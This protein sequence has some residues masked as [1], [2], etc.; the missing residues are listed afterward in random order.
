MYKLNV[1]TPLECKRFDPF[2]W[3]TK[4]NKKKEFVS[5][6]RPRFPS[7]APFEKN[8]INVIDLFPPRG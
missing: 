6:R 3:T 2:T 4:E 1:H 5:S 7:I 8:S